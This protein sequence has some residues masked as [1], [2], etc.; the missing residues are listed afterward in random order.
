MDFNDIVKSHPFVLVDFYAD[1]CEPCK[2]L[3][4]ILQDVADHFGDRLKIVKIDTE[5][6][7]EIADSFTVKS[8]PTLLLFKDGTQIWRYKGFMNTQETIKLLEAYHY[9]KENP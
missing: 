2:W 8:V 7:K 3:D 6:N 1:W 5:K 4:V 9:S